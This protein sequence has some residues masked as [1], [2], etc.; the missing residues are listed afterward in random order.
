MFRQEASLVAKAKSFLR[1]NLFTVFSQLSFA[2]TDK[3]VDSLMSILK[4]AVGDT[5]K[6]NRILKYFLSLFFLGVIAA[7]P[8]D[9]QRGRVMDS[10]TR[11]LNL[12]HEDT[13]KVNLLNEITRRHWQAGNFRDAGCLTAIDAR[14][15]DRNRS[16]ALPV[17]SAERQVA[18]EMN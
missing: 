6:V 10:L 2:Y 7:A 17:Y 12:A 16:A 14:L 1:L 5:N 4:N 18:H 15:S 11:L 8:S 3:I 13:S 9:A